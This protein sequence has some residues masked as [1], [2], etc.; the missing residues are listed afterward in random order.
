MNCLTESI[1]P[2]YPFRDAFQKSIEKNTTDFFHNTYGKGKNILKAKYFMHMRKLA[3]LSE[4]GSELKSTEE[5]KL[6]LIWLEIKTLDKGK[7]VSIKAHPEKILNG[8]LAKGD[9]RVRY[10]LIGP[11]LKCFKWASENGLE[12]PSNLDA[13]IYFWMAD[14][15]PW[16]VTGLPVFIPSAVPAE[17]D[18]P[19]FPDISYFYMQFEKKYTGDGVDYNTIKSLFAQDENE[20][21]RP[22]L[23]FKGADTTRHNS[24][25]RR[26]VVSDMKKHLPTKDLDLEIT[27]GFKKFDPLFEDGLHKKYLLDLPGKFPWSVRFKMLFLFNNY[28]T[29]IKVNE[30]WVANDDSWADPE[31]PWKQ[32]VDTFLPSS[33]YLSVM[34]THTQIVKIYEK[35]AKI[36]KDVDIINKNAREDTLEKIASLIKDEAKPENPHL[37]HKILNELSTERIYQMMFRLVMTL[38]T[39]NKV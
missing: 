2:K 9:L 33:A 13:R 35:N 19:L 18:L 32:W 5:D 24:D 15:P 37:G 8:L 6:R 14:K 17:L 10:G 16:D 20:N 28:P 31:E 34:H 27:D 23:Y 29:V 11:F 21:K 30:R 36:K 3:E 7:S 4:S 1:S 39:L 22:I 38:Y 26:T 25:L 12:I